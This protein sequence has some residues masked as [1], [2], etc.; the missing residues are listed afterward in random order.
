NK[1]RIRTSVNG[2][3]TLDINHRI[4]QDKEAEEVDEIYPYPKELLELL[5][6]LN[7]W[8][9]LFMNQGVV[10]LKYIAACIRTNGGV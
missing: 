5:K 2:N 4:K 7:I 6:K 1:I 8:D 10:K 9:H 3:L